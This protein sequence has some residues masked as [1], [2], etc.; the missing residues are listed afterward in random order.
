MKRILTLFLWL[1]TISCFSQEIK[2][3]YNP[4]Q[5]FVTDLEDLLTP[6]EESNLNQMLS[7]YEQKTSVEI[8]IL[9]TD[10]YEGIGDIGDYAIQLG[11]KWG[12][13]KKEYDNGLMIVIS[14]KNNEN[15]VAT[16]YGLEGYLTDA[17]THRMQDTFF[18]PYFK[19]GKYYEGLTLFINKCKEQIGD[20][21]SAKN[22]QIYS[23]VRDAWS[24]FWGL[25]LWIKLILLAIYV[26]LWIWN[27]LLAWYLTIFPIRIALLVVTRGKFGGGS[28]G[29]GGSRS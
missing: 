2:V 24:W 14:K 13:G 19:E 5:R 7:E 10:D 1:I 27:P 6:Q 12:V 4:E 29:G 17:F 9:T 23:T 8:A 28:F 16:G 25:P 11:E 20:E 22:N 3:T 26:A 21:Y 15:F 18:V